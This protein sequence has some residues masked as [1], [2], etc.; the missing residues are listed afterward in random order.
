MRILILG[1]S[2]QL[3]SAFLTHLNAAFPDAEVLGTS[4]KPAADAEN[5]IKF[6]PFVDDWNLLGKVTQVINCIGQIKENKSMSFEQVHKGLTTLL[7][8]HRARLGNPRIIQLSALG[9]R[10]DHPTAFLNSKAK[11]DELLL[12]HPETLV[13]RPS[14][15]CTEETLF[16]RKVRT[17][18][19][20]SKLTMGK[21]FCPKGFL[22]TCIQPVLMDDLSTFVEQSIRKNHAGIMEIGGPEVLTFREIIEW[23]TEAHPVKLLE[24]PRE[25]MD[26]FVRYFVSVWFPGLLNYD[27][28]QLLFL[29]NVVKNTP[30]LTGFEPRTTRE[31]WLH[32]LD[33]GSAEAPETDFSA[34]F[35]GSPDP[36]PA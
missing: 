23:M 2:G 1:A 26:T 27:Q 34:G 5:L 3:G 32:A 20:M 18:V 19:K 28:F 35:S 8:A 7:L 22:D 25:V 6:D 31:F 12:T 36:D 21:I 13:I 10:E 14:V 4:R 17:L 30:E 9:A 11:A 16:A 29:E 33:S 24:V 15:V